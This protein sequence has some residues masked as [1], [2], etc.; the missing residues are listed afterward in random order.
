MS[1]KKLTFDTF[2]VETIKNLVVAKDNGIVDIDTNE[3]EDFFKDA[4]QLEIY[5]TVL[6]SADKESVNSSGLITDSLKNAKEYLVYISSGLNMTLEMVDTIMNVISD[7]SPGRGLWV[8]KS[9]ESMENSIRVD[10]YIKTKQKEKN[11]KNRQDGS[12]VSI[13][14]Q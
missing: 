9:I 2:E 6:Q 12:H 14:W 10:L 4:E 13:L 5:S 1:T 11:E 8:T 7:N 3:K